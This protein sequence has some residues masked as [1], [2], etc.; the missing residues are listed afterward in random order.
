[1]W[2]LLRCF[3]FYFTVCFGCDLSVPGV[4]IASEVSGVSDNVVSVTPS[5]TPKHNKTLQFFFDVQLPFIGTSSN[6]IPVPCF[7][8]FSKI[9]KQYFKFYAR[10]ALKELLPLSNKTR[11][12]VSATYKPEKG[13]KDIFSKVPILNRL[14]CLKSSSSGNR[15]SKVTK[16]F[17]FD[18]LRTRRLFVDSVDTGRNMFSVWRQRLFEVN[19]AQY[20]TPRV[21]YCCSFAFG[22]SLIMVNVDDVLHDI[23]YSVF[24]ENSANKFLPE[25]QTDISCRL[26]ISGGNILGERVLI[27][28]F[29]ASPD[30]PALPGVL[31]LKYDETIAKARGINNKVKDVSS[32]LVK[33][34]YRLQIMPLG[35]S[36]NLSGENGLKWNRYRL[37]DSR[38]VLN[39][40]CGFTLDIYDKMFCD[41]DFQE[42]T[43]REYLFSPC[44]GMSTYWTFFNGWLAICTESYVNP[45]NYLAGSVVR[46]LVEKH[47]VP[48]LSQVLVKL[49]FEVFMN[50]STKV[51]FDISAFVF[52]YN[53]N[54]TAKKILDDYDRFENP[55][56]IIIENQYYF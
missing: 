43:G 27:H 30:L 45:K 35:V 26:K 22:T 16:D 24:K 46:N 6:I 44:V 29:N 14:S 12:L 23:A 8:M 32:Y 5:V 42:K 17:V 2:V 47:N 21:G 13:W 48:E 31:K 55:E 51:V 20:F 19:Y 53:D 39:I 28:N 41:G 37:K 10:D 49:V 7:E 54:D 38:R 11:N 9:A 52:R 3:L 25:M 36:F 50:W 34:C 18:L 1:M 40:L 15:A 4:D 33:S 56:N